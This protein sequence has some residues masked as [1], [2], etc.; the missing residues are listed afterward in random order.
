ML[1]GEKLTPE[2]Q[3]AA[4]VDAKLTDAE[5]RHQE[6][7]KALRE[8]TDRK[9]KERAA[10]AEKDREA[11]RLADEQAAI[12]EFKAEIAEVIAADPEGFEILNMA[13]DRGVE[14]VFSY[15]DD[16][17][18]KTGKRVSVKD[19]AAAVE[20]AEIDQARGFVQRSKKLAALYGAPV[21]RQP[22][23]RTLSNRMPPAP[24]T[25]EQRPETAQQRRDRVKAQ[26][27]QI[28][29]AKAGRR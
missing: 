2:Q 6:E 25:T 7:L 16:Q 21:A 20:Q 29:A 11:Q 19:A 18:A 27:D 12:R 10:Q 28:F 8:E 1:N 23:P 15:I 26:I 5:K 24:P 4:T 17:F 3:L 9:E 22:A 14:V 13:G